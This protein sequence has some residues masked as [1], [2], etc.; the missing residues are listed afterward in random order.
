MYRGKRQLTKRNSKAIS[1]EID[2]KRNAE[3]VS[4]LQ[5]PLPV[6]RPFRT[7]VKIAR[8]EKSLT[9]EAI[10][11]KNAGQHKKVS[12]RTTP[13]KVF[14]D[15]SPAHVHPEGK[16]WIQ[17]LAKQERTKAKVLTK[18]LAKSNKKV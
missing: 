11:L 3:L 10:R 18:K 14:S 7:P 5:A 12:K 6:S 13:G 1:K 15:S 4:T 16:R 17:N 2:K 9:L 8:A